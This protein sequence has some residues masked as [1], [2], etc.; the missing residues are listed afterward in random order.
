MIS[1]CRKCPCSLYI[2][3]VVFSFLLTNTEIYLK[4]SPLIMEHLANLTHNTFR[5]PDIIN[6]IIVIYI[7][8]FCK[9]TV[10][11]PLAHEV[12]TWFNVS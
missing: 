9:Y 10:C 6:I 3:K 7:L 12:T 8:I 1:S 4:W 2:L 5:K 11:T